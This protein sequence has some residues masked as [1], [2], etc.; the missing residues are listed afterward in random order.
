MGP[1]SHP[2][3]VWFRMGKWT[4]SFS[5]CLSSLSHPHDGAGGITGRQ[6]DVQDAR[7][8]EDARP[9]T[10]G[11]NHAEVGTDASEPGN[12][13]EGNGRR[14]K[15]KKEGKKTKEERN[16]A[17]WRERC[18]DA[19]ATRTMGCRRNECCVTSLPDTPKYQEEWSRRG[20]GSNETSRRDEGGKRR[21][22]SWNCGRKK[23]Q[24]GYITNV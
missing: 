11:A 7:R 3:R 22:R 2:I 10:P 23:K 20:G 14:K 17:K 4:P 18:L 1:R 5:P 12:T 21:K 8:W 15:K 24:V 9:G 6:D 19:A 16:A 13:C